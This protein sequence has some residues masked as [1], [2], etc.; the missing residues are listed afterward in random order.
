M[1]NNTFRYA[2]LRLIFNNIDLI[3]CRIPF[4]YKNKIIYSLIYKKI[5][6]IQKK[7][8]GFYAIQWKSKLQICLLYY[9][10]KS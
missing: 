4:T 2:S 6:W 10:F 5:L 9:F 1:R 8:F 7:K 3:L